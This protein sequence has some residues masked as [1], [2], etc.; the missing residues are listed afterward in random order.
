MTPLTPLEDFRRILQYSPWH[1]WGLANSADVPVDSACNDIVYEYNWQALRDFCEGLSKLPQEE[2]LKDREATYH[3]MKNIFFHILGVHDG[4]LNV[5]A[6]G[7]SANPPFYEKDFDDV[8]TMSELRDYME[9]IV[10]KE[11]QFLET[12]KPQRERDREPDRRPQ[13]IALPA[14]AIAT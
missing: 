11:E 8:R 13:R 1:F 9:K 4:W 10:A 7:E 5:T 3:S 2:L 14:P 12:L 6:Q